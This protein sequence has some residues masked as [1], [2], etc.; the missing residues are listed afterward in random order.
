MT[1]DEVLR[2]YPRLCAH[3]MAH[4]LGYLSARGAASVIAEHASGRPSYNEWFVSMVT[5]HRCPDAGSLDEALLQVG[6]EEI[7][8]AVRYRRTHTGYMADARMALA[9]VQRERRGMAA[10]LSDMAG[11]M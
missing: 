4:S 5:R 11:W 10:P 7:G 1:T 9:L 2:R 8:H 6:R 3:L